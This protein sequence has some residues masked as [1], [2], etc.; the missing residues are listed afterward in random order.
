MTVI[1][2]SSLENMSRAE[3]L[4]FIAFS[5]NG[6][7][8]NFRAQEP[9]NRFSDYHIQKVEWIMRS[10]DLGFILQNV[11]MRRVYRIAP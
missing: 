7:T 2:H 10:V 5:P 6:I 9:G 3:E 11:E 4:W 1:T 8:S